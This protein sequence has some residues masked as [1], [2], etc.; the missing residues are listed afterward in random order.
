MTLF[1]IE[2]NEWQCIVP[3][4]AETMFYSACILFAW[5]INWHL[6]LQ[7]FCFCWNKWMGQSF[8]S[9]IC[10]FYKLRITA[11]LRTCRDP[12]EI[13]AFK[14]GKHLFPCGK[15]PITFQFYWDKVL[16]LKIVN[17]LHIATFL[18]KKIL[19]VIS[20]HLIMNTINYSFP[21]IVFFI[22]H[23]VLLFVQFL[24]S[25][26]LVYVLELSFLWMD[27]PCLFPHLT[28]FRISVFCAHD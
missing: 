23:K 13:M 1:I 17:I 26:S 9:V 3:A 25:L 22:F 2:K 5:D 7:K 18:F 4:R 10:P 8:E 20:C 15:D 12:L 11:L 27:R 21:S 6:G 14:A 28:C 24:S 16:S 19:G